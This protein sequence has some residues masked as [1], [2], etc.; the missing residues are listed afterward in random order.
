MQAC[1]LASIRSRFHVRV[2]KLRRRAET[3]WSVQWQNTTWRCAGISHHLSFP[4]LLFDTRRRSKSAGC[5]LGQL[6]TTTRPS[7]T[8]SIATSSEHAAC[9]APTPT[10]PWFS[11]PPSP[12]VNVSATLNSKDGATSSSRIGSRRPASTS[13]TDHNA[14]NKESSECEWTAACET[15]CWNARSACA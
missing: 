11:C 2:F 3:V 10:I 8:V 5:C 4:F 9:S 13:A 12:G 6:W 7:F 14:T 1:A 15:R